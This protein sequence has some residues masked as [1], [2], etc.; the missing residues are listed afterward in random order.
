MDVLPRGGRDVEVHDQLD[1][2]DVQPSGADVGHHQHL[3]GSAAAT[4]KGRGARRRTH[5]QGRATLHG[6]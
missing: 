2:R 5:D 4:V 6:V 3:M 1:R